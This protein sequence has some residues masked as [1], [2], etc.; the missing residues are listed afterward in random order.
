MESSK[1]LYALLLAG[2]K[3]KRFWPLSREENPKQLIQLFSS[4]TLIEETYERIRP[5]IPQER[6]L[7]AT[8]QAL[9]MRFKGLFSGLDARNFI[10]EPLPRNTAPCIAVAARKAVARD[11]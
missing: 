10:V 3:G 8:S 7:L 1:H 9:M 4:Q 11:P 2:G 5:L 6:V